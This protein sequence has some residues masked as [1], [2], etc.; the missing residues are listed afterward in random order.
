MNLRT[1]IPAFAGMTAL[2]LFSI[3][4]LVSAADTTIK[5]GR[6]ELINKGESALFTDGVKL[7]RGPDQ[8]ESNQM[9]TNRERDKVTVTGNVRLLRRV[10]STE[11]WKGFGASGHYNTEEGSGYLLGDNR[12][13][14]RV[15]HT[16]VLSSTASR[17]VT[18]TADR[19]DFL[20]DTK[21]AFAQ[22]K[23]QGSTVDPD[24]GD[25]YEFWSDRAEF[26]GEE[27]KLTLT[28]ETQPLVLHTEEAGGRRTLRGDKIVYFTDDRRMT[29]E[30]KSRAVFEGNKGKPKK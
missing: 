29:S 13:Q 3:L 10:S 24:T 14:A 15:I 30:G 9:R 22:G 17:V 6:M 28:G 2:A 11:T 25:K 18:V 23:V 5:G 19:I 26:D 27:K 8:V 7:N 4:S 20:R 21:K 1:W 12:N 16:E